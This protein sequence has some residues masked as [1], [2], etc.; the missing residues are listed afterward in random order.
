[1][2]GKNKIGLSGTE[3]LKKAQELLDRLKE[4]SV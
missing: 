1:M 3:V 2:L 4:V